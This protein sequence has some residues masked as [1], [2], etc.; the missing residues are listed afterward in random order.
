MQKKILLLFLL[1]FSKSILFSQQK[2]DNPFA[3]IDP[4][5]LKNIILPRHPAKDTVRLQVLSAIVKRY[6]DDH[7]YESAYPY[8]AEMAT[9]STKLKNE[10]GL[11]GYYRYMGMREEG[12]KHPDKAMEYYDSAVWV[13]RDTVSIMGQK[14]LSYGLFRRGLLHGY[15]EDYYSALQDLTKSARIMDALN[16]N[17][18]R[19]VYIVISDMF[20]E[21][22]KPDQA[23][24]YGLKQIAITETTNKKNLIASSYARY[25]G[26]KIRE[27]KYEEA[28][29]YL[30]KAE[31]TN[32]HGTDF[33]GGYELCLNFGKIFIEQSQ[34][35]SA[36]AYLG[37]C[38]L[39]AEKGKHPFMIKGALQQLTI[40]NLNT[41][42]LP[43]ARQYLDQYKVVLDSD[44]VKKD[45]LIFCD[46]SAQYFSR[47]GD[48]K[49]A[50]EYSQQSLVYKDSIERD[51]SSKQLN[52]LDIRYRVSAKQNEL[53]RLQKEKELQDSR[54][55]QQSTINKVY[56]ASIAV[57]LL[58]GFLTFRNF[59]NKQMLLKQKE[60][61]QARKISELEKDKQL[62]AASFMMKG[63]EEERSRL[64]KDLHDG[65]GGLL[66][67]VKHS[68]LNMKE[69]MILTAENSKAFERSVQMID[70]SV[71]ELRRIAHNM[72]PEALAKFGLSDAIKDYCKTINASGA[73][74]VTYQNFGE[75]EK[76]DKS[77][78]TSV[79]RIIQE[80]INNTIKHAGATEVLVQ[81]VCNPDRISIAVE[82]NGSGFNTEDLQVSSG[83]GWNNIR[84]RVDYLKGNID[85]KSEPGKGTSVNIELPIV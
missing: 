74:Q 16:D 31:A 36:R 18:L 66:S 59:R 27:G 54:L 76:Y 64:A 6:A 13:I 4:D 39:N 47:S 35:D 21:V 40:L 26:Y 85:M 43:L 56:I 71:K 78:E 73:V 48:Y 30:R 67:G 2:P 58:V 83:A 37:E 45:R 10:A 32:G 20:F 5:S 19:T 12:F 63:Q 69:N 81:T 42:N 44:D 62:T 22:E 52:L 34:Y 65:L 28:L 68:I 80:L 9:I 38:L 23:S 17:Y 61:L 3:G 24:Y 41:G 46:L 79:Y 53:V 11:S 29:L 72:M 82:D 55:K 33:Y 8:A 84:S 60:E 57:L 49:K 25:A 77:V 75:V 50:F 51:A 15:L 70:N 1:L 14:Q 7:D